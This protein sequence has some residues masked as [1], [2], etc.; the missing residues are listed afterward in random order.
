METEGI[1]ATT[2]LILILILTLAVRVMP[3][4]SK[5]LHCSFRRLRLMRLMIRPPFVRCQYWNVSNR[6]LVHGHI[7]M[8]MES[9]LELQE[10]KRPQHAPKKPK[11]HQLLCSKEVYIYISNW[12]TSVCHWKWKR[13][14]WSSR[15]HW[16]I[17][18]LH[19]SLS[20][21]VLFVL[22]PSKFKTT[23]FS[24]SSFV[25]NQSKQSSNDIVFS[26]SKL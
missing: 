2:I 20:A 18:W 1:V 21:H 12:T 4:S 26:T 19:V 10:T 24:V 11:Q 7:F 16:S 25:Q 13:Q 15:H 14:R 6:C 3:A 8:P 23:R 22:K 5:E 17:D 9:I